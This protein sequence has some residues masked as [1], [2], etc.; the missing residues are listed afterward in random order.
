MGVFDAF[1]LGL[2]VDLR[3]QVEAALGFRLVFLH[4]DPVRLLVGFL[5]NPGHLP[6]HLHAGL[7]SGI[8]RGQA[9]EFDFY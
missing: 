5:P 1:L 4:F 2:S 6:G 3:V 9:P 7:A 8:E